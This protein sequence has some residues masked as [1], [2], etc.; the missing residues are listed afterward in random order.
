MIEIAGGYKSSV[1]LAPEIETYLTRLTK[2]IYD[3]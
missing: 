1:N 3:E 2:G